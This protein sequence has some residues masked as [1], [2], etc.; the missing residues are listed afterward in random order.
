MGNLEI[1]IISTIVGFV[2]YIQGVVT[3]NRK[4]KHMEI[5]VRA[6]VIHSAYSQGFK[7]GENNNDKDTTHGNG[8]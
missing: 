2:A 6:D 1:V 3:A 4:F 7:D 8:N 5:A